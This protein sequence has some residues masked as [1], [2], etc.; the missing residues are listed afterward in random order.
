M[1]QAIPAAQLDGIACCDYLTV[2]GQVVFLNDTYQLLGGQEGEMLYYLA[3]NIPEDVGTQ[4]SITIQIPMGKFDMQAQEYMHS[5]EFVLDTKAALNS[6]L[7]AVHDDITWGNTKV[8]LQQAAFS[9]VHGTITVTT[10]PIDPEQPY[11]SFK[12]CLYTLSGQPFQ[13]EWYH[14]YGLTQDQSGQVWTIYYIPTAQWPDQL[15]LAEA[16]QDGS[17][18]RQRCLTLELKGDLFQ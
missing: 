8:S 4:E 1:W 3:A 17:V 11:D 14:E 9:P 10:H 5:V 13:Q 6:A 15:L 18:D 2:D 16:Q 12:P 7:Y